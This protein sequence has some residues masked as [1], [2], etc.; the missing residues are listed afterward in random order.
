MR[1][2]PF[3]TKKVRPVGLTLE[4]GGEAPRRSWRQSRLLKAATIWML[5]VAAMLS[6]PGQ[7]I[8]EFPVQEGD[9][10]RGDDLASTKAF[11]IFKTDEQIEAEYE[12]IRSSATPFFRKTNGALG[13]A[14]A[15]IDSLS[16][17]LDR[18][19]EQYAEWK[20]AAARDD[21][22][23]AQRDSAAF[24]RMLLGS[25]LDLL[26]QHWSLIIES[27]EEHNPALAS[28]RRP[29]G[30]SQAIDRTVLDET[31]AL[32]RSLEGRSVINIPKDSI[33]TDEVVVLDDLV[34][35]QSFLP[36]ERLSDISDV[37]REARRYFETRHPES[38]EIAAIGRRLFVQAFV[39]TLV[40]LPDVTAAEIESRLGAVSTTPGMVREGEVIVRNGEIVTPGIK[41]KL[42]SLARSAADRGG[43]LRTWLTLLGQLLISLIACTIFF[44]FLYILRRD[45][46]EDN[47]DVVLMSVLL[48]LLIGLFAASV[49]L[50]AVPSLAVPVT[51]A[52][53]LLTVFYDSRV[54]FFGTLSL[55]LLGGVYFGYDF[56][57]FSVTMWAGTIAVFSVRDIKR[58]AP[59]IT[60]AGL[61]F[62]AYTTLLGAFWLFD[63]VPTGRFGVEELIFVGINAVLV[64]LAQPLVLIFERLFGMTTDVTLLELSDTNRDTLREL[65]IRAPGTFNHSLQVANLSEAAAD[66]IGANALL[67]RVGALYHDI[68]K[69]QKP[70]YFV[71]NQ[72]A[73]FNPHDRLK[74]R[75]SALIISSHVRDG[76]E[77]AKEE[78]LPKVVQDFI[79]MHHGTARMEYFYNKALQLAGE[80]DPSPPEVEFRYPGPRPNTRETG[81]VMLADSVEAAS[82]SI[83]QPTPRK[84]E[85]LVDSII[86]A[87][88]SDGQLDFCP[89]TFADINRIRETVLSM[90]SGMHHFRVKYP[91]QEQEEAKALEA[92]DSSDLQ[93]EPQDGTGD[94]G[95]IE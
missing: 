65:S 54:G 6:F 56:K 19:L 86:E 63:V 32:V 4:S 81:I 71:E 8:Y 27:F 20:T 7:R 57:F 43:R 89:L 66:A 85:N 78:R 36:T 79:P 87:R 93:G 44:L 10:W 60:T 74:P 69:M 62:L 3:G 77:R 25:D 48:A 39:P 16:S 76:L 5:V 92:A 80:D 46:F 47:R 9:V 14:L 70:E 91:G 21:R 59:F 22:S 28:S 55:A 67:A 24:S 11:P 90:L 95:G 13:L 29:A 30:G 75:M 49:R 51:I 94:T 2:W 1:F 64:L 26:P 52:S 34:R 40:Y 23:K 61:V 72:Q 35:S 53:V 37:R 18:V 15:N 33:T 50:E 31:R 42:N 68:G 82:R 83:E 38:S 45:Y 84:L 58:R 88:I 41:A 73:G 12:E 17:R